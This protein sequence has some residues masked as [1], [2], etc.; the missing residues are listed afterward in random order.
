MD[1]TAANGK[2]SEEVSG[3]L[4]EISDAQ[5]R[6]KEWRKFASELVSLYECEDR[7]GSPF[8]ILFSNTETLAPALYNNLPRP[9]VKRRFKD[10]NPAAK[11]AATV[12]ERSLAFL[13]D[14]DNEY[15][16]PFD[17]LMQQSVL[18]ALVPGRGQVRFEY[19]AKFGEDGQTVAT[20]TICGKHVPWNRFFHGYAKHW[21][22]VPWVAFEHFMSREE[23][24]RN[25]EE[26]GRKL[27]LTATA[28]EAETALA[29]ERDA[30]S[31]DTDSSPS[32]G[33]VYQIWD[34]ESREV[35]FIS[36][37]APTPLKR[38]PD[39]LDLVGFFP[40]PR[41]LSFFDK[42]KCLVPVPLY[43]SY[44]TQAQELN[45]ITT[46]INRIVRA[47][48]IRGFYDATVEGLD[49][50]LSSEDNT[51][52]PAENVAALQQGQTL[53]KAIWFMPLEKLIVV[54]QQLYVQREQVKQV[55]YEITGISDILRGA[56]VASE[57]ATAQNIKNQWGTLRLKR[58]Q[59]RVAVFVRDCLRIMA[60]IAC[61]KFSPQTFGEMTGV[62]LPTAQQKQQAQALQAQLQQAQAA[63]QQL[64][65]AMAAQTRQ[66]GLILSSPSIEEV[67]AI[68]RNDVRRNFQ[69]EVETNS[70]VDAEATEDK[71]D[72]GEFLN[73][74][75][76]YFNGIAP[77]IQSNTLPFDAAKEILLGVVRRYRFGTEVEDR[78]AEMQAPPPAQIPPEVQKAQQ[79]IQ[80][81]GEKVKEQELELA[82]RE[83]EFEME[84]AFALR[85][86]E[87][88]KQMALKEVERAAKEKEFGLDLRRRD[89]EHSLG[90]AQEDLKSKAGEVES[91]E[92][93]VEKATEG[94]AE[95]IQTAAHT[96][97]SE[98]LQAN[99]E[100]FTKLFTQALGEILQKPRR[101]RKLPDGTWE[102]F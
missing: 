99:R 100:D 71:Q 89:A 23:L 85:E 66:L 86:I 34:K 2:M 94:Q 73:A 7:D 6:E 9:E 79:E 76:Q 75:A 102:T 40:C 17:D 57:T 77:M 83:K 3:W 97:A 98:A 69:I 39:P 93:E 31:E 52:L 16:V 68:I 14:N 41:P 50:L 20:E 92:S 26:A 21:Q 88:S 72:L 47:L 8:N 24:E 49:R 65:P 67:E 29:N 5:A 28:K 60:E 45:T 10:A 19:E 33:Q 48:K 101:A 27:P 81:A 15:G 37:A 84:K 80:K 62:Q 51:L 13:L 22:D 18:E 64:P 32:L 4:E 70:T 12:I 58:M 1:K 56:S 46:R 54:L 95:A 91:R 38:V 43:A 11:M 42:I 61:A 25:F 59:K 44:E 53:E 87:F 55:I 63:G 78:I 90:K 30:Y 82:A 35:L 36:P 96:A 74:L